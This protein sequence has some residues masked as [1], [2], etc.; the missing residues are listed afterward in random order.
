[1]RLLK[2]LRRDAGDNACRMLRASLLHDT[3][4]SPRPGHHSAARRE[5]MNVVLAL[6][7]DDGGCLAKV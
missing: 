2:E 3:E 5:P 6:F 7:P 4:V 1:M